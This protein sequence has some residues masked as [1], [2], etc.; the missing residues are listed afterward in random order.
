MDDE[1]IIVNV[2][3][4]DNE[5]ELSKDDDNVVVKNVVSNRNCFNKEMTVVKFPKET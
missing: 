1:K 2:K 4:E 3:D 5:L